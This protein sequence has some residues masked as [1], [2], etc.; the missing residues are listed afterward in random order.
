[1]LRHPAR[2][3][4][5]EGAAFGKT[6]GTV[7]GTGAW[8]TA[9]FALL[10]SAA[11]GCLCLAIRQ[12]RTMPAWTG[13]VL[14]TAAV[15]LLSQC[16]AFRGALPFP[17]FLAFI[18]MGDR[19]RR[20]GIASGGL[21]WRRPGQVEF[22][23]VQQGVVGD[24]A[25]VGGPLAQGFPVAFPAAADVAWRDGGK[26][27]QFHGVDLDPRGTGAI[28]APGPDFGPAPQPEGH[29]DVARHHSVTQILAELHPTMLRLL[30]PG[31][32]RARAA[33][34][35]AQITRLCAITDDVG[36]SRSAAPIGGAAALGEVQGQVFLDFGCGTGRSAAFLRSL[37]AGRVYGV[38][39]DQDMIGNALARRHDEVASRVLMRSCRCRANRWT[40]RSA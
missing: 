26:G 6:V 17:Q 27:H 4:T 20:V 36:A 3:G 24:R 23:P 9:Y 10:A 8:L 11:I 40:G 15:R 2:H 13:Y 14:L 39:R 1:M 19:P 22:H 37:G 16:A 28:P 38:D 29:G 7:I 31:R 33:P 12:T 35:E 34:A 25:G 30:P 5:G 18:V 32:Q 21:V